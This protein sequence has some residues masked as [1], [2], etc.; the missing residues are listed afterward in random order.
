MPSTVLAMLAKASR[1]PA[2]ASAEEIG[3]AVASACEE[4]PS[5]AANAVATCMRQIVRIST[6]RQALAGFLSTSPS[7]T[8]AYVGAKVFKSIA[9]RLERAREF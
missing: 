5:R 2:G 7:K 4:D 9:S 1:V 8:V 3:R 6:V